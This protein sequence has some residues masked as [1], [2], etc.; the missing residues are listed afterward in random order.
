MSL[1]GSWWKLATLAALLCSLLSSCGGGGGGGASS[2]GGGESAPAPGSAQAP[3]APVA[4]GVQAAQPPDRPSTAFDV[5]KRLAR[6]ISLG[7]MLETSR[8]EGAGGGQVLTDDLFDVVKLAG[9]STVRIPIGW[10]NHADLQVPYAINERFFQ[11]IDEVI[12]GALRRRLNVVIDM[13]NYSQLVQGLGLG[14]TDEPLVVVCRPAHPRCNDPASPDYAGRNNADPG[15]GPVKRD[16]TAERSVVEARF[17]A[18]WSQIA[19][20]YQNWPYNNPNGGSLIFELLNEPSYELERL[21]YSTSSAP[22]ANSIEEAGTDNRWN[23]LLA[24]AHAAV[25]AVDSNRFIVVGPT[26]WSDPRALKYL[27]LP[28]GDARIIVTFHSYQPYDFTFTGVSGFFSPDGGTVRC[29]DARQRAQIAAGLDEAVAWAGTRWPL[30]FGEFG[31]HAGP[32]GNGQPGFG[33]QRLPELASR[34]NFNRVVR[35]EAEKRGLP[36]TV[37][38]LSGNFG[39]WN[40]RQRTWLPGLLESLIP[41]P[42][43][44]AN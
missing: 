2:G 19:T 26:A 37:W 38:A 12:A 10:S 14:D 41:P 36:W 39:L 27:V 40:Y 35:E 31:S 43:A 21:R 4:P 30:W 23:E 18:M 7:E 22:R 24:R 33:G 8:G 16:A 13:H 3:L 20:R 42:A 9:F 29:C 11:R 44:P 17:V 6:G 1:R 28:Q 15:R 25:R 32:N 5:T 34:A